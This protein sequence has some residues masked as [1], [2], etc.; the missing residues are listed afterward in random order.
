MEVVYKSTMLE[1]I[2][3]E[4]EK[5]LQ[6]GKQI[7]KI[8]L[9]EQEWS[10]FNLETKSEYLCVYISEFPQFEKTPRSPSA[11]YQEILIEKGVEE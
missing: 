2:D 8:V 6:Q 3:K 5:A 9:T 7:E 11:K 1:K 4:I 10:L